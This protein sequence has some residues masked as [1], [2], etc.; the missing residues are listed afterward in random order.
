[1]RTSRLLCILSMLF[2]AVNFA[3]AQ[4]FVNLT[5]KPKSMTVGKGLLQ[6]KKNFKIYCEGIDQPMTEEVAKFVTSVNSATGLNGEI[7]KKSSALFN[8]GKL[9]ST[10]HL[11]TGGYTLQVTRNKVSIRAN[12]AIGLYYAFQS[13]KKILP[14]N[15]MAGVNDPRVVSYYLP[16]VNIVDEPRFAY[17]GFM[18]D[19][20]RHFFSVAEIKRMLDVMSY[21]KMNKFHW[22]LT[23]DQGWRA[24]IKKYPELTTIGAT[25]PNS[26]FTSLSEVKAYWINRPYGPYY[27]TQ[28]EMKDVVAYAAARHIDIIPEVDMPGHFCAALAAYPQFSCN[29]DGRHDVQCDGGIYTDVLNVANPK[30]M[31]FV[32]DIIDELTEIFPYKYIHIGG[33][34]CPT[35]AWES[36]ADCQKLYKDNGFTSWRQL[37]SWFINKVDKYVKSKGRRLSMWNESITEKGA[38]L[39]MMKATEAPIYCWYPA[40]ESVEKAH[41]L[42]L[43]VIY[44]TW[45]PYYINRRQGA[46]PKDPPGAA[47]G[48]DNVKATYNKVIP[49]HVNYGVQATFWS[50]WVSDS[51]YLEWLALPRLIAIAEAGWTPQQLRTGKFDDFIKRAAADTVMLNYNG[52]RYCKY[53]MP[54]QKTKKEK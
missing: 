5:P 33:D 31:Q 45:G 27:Y 9:P 39:E 6:L 3:N 23:D 14:P 12:D 53:F 32:Y 36:N 47:D 7:S 46:G 54:R 34:E 8:V 16:I 18:L 30:A 15:V 24:E 11:K 20:S 49:E 1:M 19:V 52:Y 38:D 10:I 48:S 40:D 17:R 22:H 25:A 2:I 51:T 41:Q 50:E 37:Q 26:R 42:D 28:E 29:P 21:Y 13:V 43:P 35:K 4:Q 44:T